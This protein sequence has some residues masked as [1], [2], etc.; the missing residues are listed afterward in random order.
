M[1]FIGSPY[2]VILSGAKNLKIRGSGWNRALEI[3]R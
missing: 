3:L 1:S 2:F